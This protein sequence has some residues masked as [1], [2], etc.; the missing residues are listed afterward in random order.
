M[1][2]GREFYARPQGAPRRQVPLRR[3]RMSQVEYKQKAASAYAPSAESYIYRSNLRTARGNAA[4][5]PPGPAFQRLHG[6]GRVQVD[7]HIAQLVAGLQVLR[8][9]VDVQAVQNT[10]LMADSTP[11]WLRWMCRMRCLPRCA[12][13]ATSGKLTDEGAGAV[14]AVA[15]SFSATSRPMLACAS[16]VEPPI[17]GVMMTLSSPRS[18]RLELVLVAWARP[19]THPPPRPAASLPLSAWASGSIS[20]TVPRG[21]DEDGAG[22]HGRD[23]RRAHHPLRGG[24]LRHA[25]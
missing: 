24:Q 4:C 23:L 20:T 6:R 18:W 16:W 22:L 21:V 7:H 10:W 5:H 25:G 13:S 12:G 19:G 2:R 14:V 11:G 9:D 3:S 8:G 17:W 1:P 15:T